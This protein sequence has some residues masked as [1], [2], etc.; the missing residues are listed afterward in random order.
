MPSSLPHPPTK[1]H[2][3]LSYRCQLLSS[4]VMK[5]LEKHMLLLS[6]LLSRPRK[7]AKAK[8]QLTT[9]TGLKKTLHTT[10][11]SYVCTRWASIMGRAPQTPVCISS[12]C[13]LFT[14]LHFMPPCLKHKQKPR[15]AFSCCHRNSYYN[16]KLYLMYRSPPSSTLQQLAVQWEGY[17]ARGGRGQA[18]E[19]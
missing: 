2:V 13:L 1:G 4:S 5:N 6:C 14:N 12:H 16:L 15:R 17:A 19:P 11:R 9:E 7:S 3:T 18:K 8:L 10:R